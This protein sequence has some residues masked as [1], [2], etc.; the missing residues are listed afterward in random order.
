[1]FI[2]SRSPLCNFNVLQLIQL[3]AGQFFV[4][5]EHFGENPEF[6][7][8]FCMIGALPK[9]WCSNCK[10]P[11]GLKDLMDFSPCTADEV[12]KAMKMNIK[13]KIGKPQNRNKDL[14]DFFF[15]MLHPNPA[16]RMKANELLK[17]RWLAKSG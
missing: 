7:E 14:V 12:E 17:H 11:Q 8:L 6:R 15:K 4:K 2:S 13:E 3:F 1:M 9:E 16:Q 5:R 10:D